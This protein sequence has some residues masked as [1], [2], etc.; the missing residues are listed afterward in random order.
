M[1]RLVLAGG[2]HAHLAAL[3]R[4]GKVTGRG[5]RVTLVSPARV[6][7]YSGMGP[8]IL[9]GY[10]RPR[11]AAFH[12]AKL[13][14]RGGGVFRRASVV[15]IRP[16]E[17]L[18]E[19][20]DGS[21]ISYDVLSLNLGS[22]ARPLPGDGGPDCFPVKPVANLARARLRALRLLRRGQCNL[23]IFGGGPAGVE[24]AGN[25][26]RLGRRFP[27]RVAVTLVAG[28]RLLHGFQERVR[29][30]CREAL[31]DSGVTVLEDNRLE[32]LEPGTGM[33]DDGRRLPFQLAVA[34]P[35]ILPSG[36]MAESGLPAGP[37][38]GL[39]T[40]RFLRCP[41][42]PEIFGGGDCIDF[43]PAPLDKVGVYAVRQGGLLADNLLAALDGREPAPFDPGDPD[44][45]LLF[46]LG[47]GTA[48]FRKRGIVTRSK[49]SWW[50]KDRI[51]R[52]FVRRHQ[53]A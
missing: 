14:E 26:A 31:A 42:H 28:H 2:G 33:L 44:Y 24:V 6:H 39:L 13:A 5:H 20:D 10:Y 18:L 17:R 7:C 23:A 8:G 47:D 34:A 21:T 19:L 29:R 43:G 53:V 50:L 37:S 48:L 46:N 35:G 9:G 12:V 49:A 3:K 38:G 22:G 15:R 36:L 45:L 25:L 30:L 52:R 27:G 11:E 32:Y 40:D 1:A 41:E 16:G 51:D 4:L